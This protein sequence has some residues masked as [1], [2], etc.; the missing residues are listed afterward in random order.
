MG[1]HSALNIFKGA[2]EEGFK[3]ICV[4]KESD[5]I[6]YERFSLADDLILVKDF[7]EVLNE[8]V[9]ERLRHLNTI[10][11]PHGSFTAYLGTEQMT[12]SL[13]VPVFGN[14]ELL[15]WEASREKQKQWLS[16][17]ALRLPRTFQKPEEISGLTIAKLPGAR[18]GKGYFLSNSAESFHEKAEGMISRG[19]LSRRDLSRIHL[20]EDI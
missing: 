8:N 16:K 2:R 1:S 6:L 20:Q 14:R 17:A 9:Q 13:H 3:T 4:C 7:A 19:L 12:E 18:G 10:L 5:S 15:S 11:V